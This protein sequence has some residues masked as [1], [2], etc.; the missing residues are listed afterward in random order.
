MF[1]L[2][3]ITLSLHSNCVIVLATVLVDSMKCVTVLK[4]VLL[5]RKLTYKHG[6][7]ESIGFTNK[8][9]YHMRLGDSSIVDMLLAL[10]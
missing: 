1:A 8:R 3:L 10:Y 7:Y 9:L 2:D 4:K 6:A 5:S